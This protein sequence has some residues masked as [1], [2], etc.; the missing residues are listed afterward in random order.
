MLL[1]MGAT[2]AAS[3]YKLNEQYENGDS[4]MRVR[5]LGAVE[6][7]YERIREHELVELSGLAWDADDAVL[8]AVSDHGVLFHLEP[9]FKDGFLVDVAPTDA[10]PL[11]SSSG[12]ILRGRAADAEGLAILGGRN[13][14][15]NDAELLVSF[16]RVPRINRY[17]PSGQF[18]QHHALP[19]QLTTTYEGSNGGFESVTYVSPIGIVTAP[20]R[21][22]DGLDGNVHIIYDLN[23][24]AWSFPRFAAPKSSLVAIEALA[25]KSLITLERSFV[26]VWH[27]L[28]IVLRQSSPLT[29]VLGGA[30]QTEEIAAFNSYDGWRLDNFEG[31]TRHQ[32]NKFF[33]VSDDNE[34]VLQRTLLI[35][36]EIL[37]ES[38]NSVPVAAGK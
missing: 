17:S 35:Y 12:E 32:G 23:G 31:M 26:S 7:H 8:Y 37:D 15:K 19:E 20:E 13:G 28:Q 3:V 10:Y 14:I 29:D 27:P 11:Y 18:Q 30:L 22:K 1:M 33:L 4:F 5:L 6:L 16:E 36:L 2:Q 38:D 24:S 25:D 34:N 9:K 21:A